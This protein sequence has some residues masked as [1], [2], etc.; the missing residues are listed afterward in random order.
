MLECA[1]AASSE[2]VIT[3]DRH[4]LEMGTFGA[5]KIMTVSEFL[6]HGRGR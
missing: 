3:G 5:M 1:V 4:L 6:V 2:T